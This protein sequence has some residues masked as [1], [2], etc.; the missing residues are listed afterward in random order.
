MTADPLLLKVA[1]GDQCEVCTRTLDAIGLID[2]C[3]T[4]NET[5]KVGARTSANVYEGWESGWGCVNNL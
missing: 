3:C 5:H 2:L 4:V 1:W